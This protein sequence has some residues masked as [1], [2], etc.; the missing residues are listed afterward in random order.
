MSW[1]ECCHPRACHDTLHAPFRDAMASFTATGQHHD[2]YQEQMKTVEVHKGERLNFIIKQLMSYA[3]P[4]ASQIHKSVTVQELNRS[5]AGPR[6]AQ[7]PPLA[8]KS[9]FGWLYD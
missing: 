8:G 5:S 7:S 2:L 4:A 1:S 9:A 6:G 3:R